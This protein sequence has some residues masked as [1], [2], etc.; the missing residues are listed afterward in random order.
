MKMEH[1]R[2]HAAGATAPVSPHSAVRT[3]P[4]LHP[5]AAHYKFV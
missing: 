2:R 1:P 4:L 5:P 3:A